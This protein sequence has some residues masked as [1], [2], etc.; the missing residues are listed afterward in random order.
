VRFVVYGAGAVGGLLGGSLHE[1][2]HDVVLIARGPHLAAIQ[3]GGLRMDTPAGSVTVAVPAV[4]H[5]GEI[6]LTA[7]DVVF[8]GM[9]S[10]HTEDALRTLAGVAPPGVAVVS[11]QN[12]VANEPAALRWFAD[13]YGMCVYCPAIHLEPGVVE[14]GWAPVR[15]TLDIGPYSDGLDARARAIAAAIDSTAFDSVARPDIMR[16]K[17]AK[18]LTNLNNAI[19]ALC[20]PG[21]RAA[22]ATI[23]DE[24]RAEGRAC[25]AAADIPVA[26]HEE[27][28]ARR[29]A[30]TAQAMRRGA[31]R[32]GSSTWQSL[33]RGT[34]SIE[35]DYLN[36]EIVMLGRRYG[37]PT[38]V[39][40]ALQRLA[41]QAA[42]ERWAPGSVSA[43][44]LIRMVRGGE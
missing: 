19:D 17:Y 20:G 26:D 30:V 24:A 34:G 7:D 25:L 8:L 42:R 27:V 18:L 1:V 9:K 40:E 3:A 33:A 2:G 15:G 13:V 36:G 10:Q 44:D 43:D 16:W 35:A 39:N 14:S 41:N 32:P 22:V 37:V 12:G 38:P 11:V 29:Q 21:T 5:P 6:G 4:S 28:V 23:D 31:S